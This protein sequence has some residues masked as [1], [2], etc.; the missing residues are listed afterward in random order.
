MWCGVFAYELAA[1]L[2]RFNK[3]TVSQ[4]L[5]GVKERK[6]HLLAWLHLLLSGTLQDQSFRGGFSAWRGL[7]CDISHLFFSQSDEHKDRLKVFLSLRFVTGA[8]IFL[9][10][11]FREQHSLPPTTHYMLLCNLWIVRGGRDASWENPPQ[12][13]ISHEE[14]TWAWEEF[15]DV[16]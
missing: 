5:L 12:P 15:R 1:L 4:Y 10:G 16:K 2:K 7:S 6:N 3:F 9:V 8:Q 11:Q 13:Q 14:I